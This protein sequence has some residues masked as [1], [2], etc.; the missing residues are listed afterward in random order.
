MP[1]PNLHSAAEEPRRPWS[2]S[3]AIAE[4]REALRAR[5]VGHGAGTLDDAECLELLCDLEEAEAPALLEAFGSVPEVLGATL[6]DLKRV[7][8]E[9]A[10]C[11]I[12]LAQELA[13]R[14]LVRPLRRRSVL[15]SWSAVATHL[16]TVMGGAPREQFRV[17]FLDRRNRLI[18]D[19]VLGEGT[20][21]HAPVYPREVVRRALEL[22]AS[23]MVVAHNHPSGD[24]NPSSMDVEMTRRLVEAARALGM[25][26]HDHLVV[27]GQDV[28]SLKSLGLM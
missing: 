15:S 23:A 21:D 19:E 24:P 12:K 2:F 14:M 4:R 17:L 11:R 3:P 5:M 16:R 7:A 1:M 26:I 20:V 22:H 6:A 18:A 28:A 27:A 8:G 10:A 9:A 25:T 13:A